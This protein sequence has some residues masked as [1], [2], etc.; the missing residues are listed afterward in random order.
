ME[1][2]RKY[3]KCLGRNRIYLTKRTLG[4]R[5]IMR[6][7]FKPPPKWA[8]FPLRRT[9]SKEE[10]LSK[11]VPRPCSD[12]EKKWKSES[13]K[14][15]RTSTRREPTEFRSC[16]MRLGAATSNLFSTC[17]ETE[18]KPDRLLP[19][20]MR[21]REVTVTWSSGW[22]KTRVQTSV[23]RTFRERPHYWWP[24]KRSRKPLLNS[25]ESVAPRNSRP[26]AISNVA[27]SHV[28][29][30]YIRGQNHRL[31]LRKS[32]EKGQ[33]RPSCSKHGPY[34]GPYC[35]ECYERAMSGDATNE[36]VPSS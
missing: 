19:S 18:Q 35:P 16:P 9:Y 15:V 11:S 7:R 17:S 26:P 36:T 6:P 21:L 30:R 29:A 4:P 3:E 33:R 22:S 1:I 31:K 24:S 10:R 28:P 32:V 13:E 14:T 2:W 25:L 34:D 20:T 12:V 27:D 8:A 5:P 23:R